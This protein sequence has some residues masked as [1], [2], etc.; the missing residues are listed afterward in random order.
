[1]ASQRKSLLHIIQKIQTLIHADNWVEAERVVNEALG[2]HPDDPLLLY[3]CGTV[4]SNTKRYGSA[5][6]VL[7]AAVERAPEMWEAWANLGGCYRREHHLELAREALKKAIAIHSKEPQVYANIAACYIN[8]GCAAEGEPFA[9][10]AIEMDPDNRLARWNLSLLLLEQCKWDEGFAMYASGGDQKQRLYRNYWAEGKTPILFELEQLK[11]DEVVVVHGEQGLGD[12]VLFS[13]V[14]PELIALREDHARDRGV[15]QAQAANDS[16]IIIESHSRL[17]DVLRRSFPSLDIHGTRDREFLSWATEREI[18]WS[19][20]IGNLAKFFRRKDA[21]FPAHRGYLKAN[22]ALTALYRGQLEMIAQG[23]PIV[24]VSWTGGFRQTQAHYRSIPLHDLMPI[25]GQDAC[26]VSMQHDP[27]EDECD[28]LAQYTH[29]R[30]HRFPQAAAATSMDKVFA[31]INA[32]DLLI[33]VANSSYHFA[34]SIGR[35]AWVLNPYRCAWR[36]V[37][38]TER[39][40]WYPNT[41]RLFHQDESCQWAPVIERVAG[42]LERWLAEAN[43]QPQK[44]AV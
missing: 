2:Q 10:R 24:G 3:F 41:V 18:H 36:E 11:E 35:E 15:A 39:S 20:P 8:E 34:G 14:L 22:P 6:H 32:C 38:R 44:E 16:R 21:D 19:C 26:F 30:V 42:E 12:E 43:I 4:L 28:D 7:K 25:I 40:Q 1:M 9:R 29:A 17:R 23:R 37:P 33:T 27:D 13:S 31:L 5:I